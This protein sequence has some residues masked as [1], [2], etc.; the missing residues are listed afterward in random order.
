MWVIEI[1]VCQHVRLRKMLKL[2]ASITLAVSP[3]QDFKSI[4]SKDLQKD[5]ALN[6]LLRDIKSLVYSLKNLITLEKES[7]TMNNIL[8]TVKVKNRF[9]NRKGR[10]ALKHLFMM[11]KVVN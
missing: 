7:K 9:K 5:K 8:T 2:L 4:T 1:S 3:I 11:V 10:V 6:Q